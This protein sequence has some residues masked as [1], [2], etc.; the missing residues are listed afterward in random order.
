MF[1]QSS[2][3]LLPIGKEMKCKNLSSKKTFY[4]S[5]T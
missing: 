1:R 4:L 5:A 2:K 3:I